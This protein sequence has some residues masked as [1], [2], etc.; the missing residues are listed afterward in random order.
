MKLLIFLALLKF[1]FIDGTL[2][3]D[4]PVFPP[5]YRPW[6]TSPPGHLQSLGH[7]RPPEGPVRPYVDRFLHPVDFWKY[8]VKD[9]LPLVYRNAITGSPAIKLWTDDYLLKNYG[10][11]DVL[12]ERKVENRSYSPR[13]MVLKG[14]LKQYRKEDI[15]VVTVLPDAMRPEV[16][17]VPSVLCGTF[18]TYLQETNL[19]IGSGGTNSIVHFDA[20]H[21][22]HCL[23][24][25]RKDPGSGSGYSNL[26]VRKVDMKKR[27]MLKR[28]PWTYATLRAGDCIYI[29]GGYIHQVRSYNRT[30]SVTTLFSP[31]SFFNSSGCDD[32]DIK[33]LPP[34]SEAPIHWTYK[35]GDRTI[36]LGYK[37][38]MVVRNNLLDPFRE[39]E[40][41]RITFKEF[42]KVLYKELSDSWQM[43]ADELF[44]K[45]ID[46]EG[47]GYY[48]KEDV[49]NMPIENLKGV[50]RNMEDP[51]GPLEPAPKIEWEKILE[52]RLAEEEREKQAHMEEMEGR[53]GADDD[54]EE[55]DDE[56]EDD[57]DEPMFEDEGDNTG[58]EQRHKHEEL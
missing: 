51:A 32:L 33:H 5:P 44:R 23:V 47:K 38:L 30:I 25:G 58:K 54:E 4:G 56:M 14:F 18:K 46:P 19:W 35:E 13:R 17:I 50:A 24:H 36:D 49:L 6:R 52:E 42:S 48:T 11:L 20:D 39:N 15:Y 28:V 57:N 26:N 16:Q 22:I 40:K 29:P 10:D 41:R 21:N 45:F 9:K 12:V 55:I 7:Q 1:C 27:P 31:T 43:E 8:H 34:M 37:N 2:V 53:D 3:N